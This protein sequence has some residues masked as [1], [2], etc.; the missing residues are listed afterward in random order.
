MARDEPE[1]SAIEAEVDGSL[2]ARIAS[3]ASDEENAADVAVLISAVHRLDNLIHHRRMILATRIPD[4]KPDFHRDDGDA[5]IEA[6]Y[7]R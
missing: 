1:L 4:A 6:T 2:R 5:G 7:R 3:T